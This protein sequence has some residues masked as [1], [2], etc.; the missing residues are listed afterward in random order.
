MGLEVD[1]VR[2]LDAI[3]MRKQMGYVTR[4]EHRHEYARMMGVIGVVS[5]K[6]C[7]GNIIQNLSALDAKSCGVLLKVVCAMDEHVVEQLGLKNIRW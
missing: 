1:D 4:M 5:R 6:R 7:V 3:S 2:N